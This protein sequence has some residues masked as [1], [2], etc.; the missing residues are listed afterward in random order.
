MIL[1]GRNLLVLR[2]P[3]L[4]GRLEGCGP[5]GAARAAM[6]R[7]AAQERGSS[8]RAR[9]VIRRD[10]SSSG[11][12]AGFPL[13]DVFIDATPSPSGTP[14]SRACLPPGQTKSAERDY[15]ALGLP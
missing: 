7:D 6:V 14:T 15:P 4:A 3:A 9:F 13:G 10:W 11:R 8:Q 5:G 2:R 12:R 1:T